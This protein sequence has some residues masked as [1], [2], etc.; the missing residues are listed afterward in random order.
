MADFGQVL[1]ELVEIFLLLDQLVL[2]LLLGTLSTLSSVLPNLLI[3]V[4]YF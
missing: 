1:A 4:S 3:V 2:E